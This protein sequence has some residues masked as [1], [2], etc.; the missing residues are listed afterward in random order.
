MIEWALPY[1][2]KIYF[3]ILNHPEC[4]NVRC[5]P[6][7]LKEKAEENLKPYL[8]LPRM[9]GVIDYMWAEDWSDKIPEFNQYTKRIDA[10]RK[11]NIRDVVPELANV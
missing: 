8:L 6:K 1:E 4:L 5:L 7:H 2:H 10:S 3:N 9:Q 11:E